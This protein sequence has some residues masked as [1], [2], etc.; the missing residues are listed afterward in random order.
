MDTLERLSL[1]K[2]EGK[3]LLSINE[4]TRKQILLQ[5][6]DTLLANVNF[7]L[8]ENKKDID[9][10]KSFLDS[11]KLDRLT[12]NPS[13]IES[14]AAG[15]KQISELETPT[16]KLLDAFI[17]ENGILI[18]KVS[19][20]IGLI[21]IIYESRPNVT[22]DC[23][24]LC[25]KSSN[26]L[27]LKGGKEANFSNLAIFNLIKEVLR[28]YDL[29][30]CIGFFE[31]KHMQD[32][33]ARDDL[34]DLIIPRGSN[35][36][37]NF[38]KQNTKIPILKHD[39]GVCHAYIHKS[40]NKDIA[41]SI[42]NNAKCSRPSVCNAL[43]CILVHKD[44]AK[45]FL[46]SLVKELKG[47]KFVLDSIS[48]EI[49]NKSLKDIDFRDLQEEDLYKEYGILEVNV[50]VVENTFEA[51]NHINKY[52]SNHSDCII[53]DDF[54]KIEQFLNEVDS[55]SVYANVSTRFSDG[56]EYGFGAEIGISTNKLHARGPVGLKELT[57]YKYKIRG[58][59]QIRI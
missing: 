48:K 59:G 9:L 18:E 45:S 29:Q 1:V 27:V 55:A 33:L 47:V 22:S 8:K 58:N 3:K 17:H 56:Y 38:I 46:P 41:L 15:V 42:C 16:N 36:L 52:S 5:I 23:I 11:S 12:L 51:I 37:I 50:K 10:A 53:S 24:A 6:H 43:E 28:K 13:R 44:I 39:A 57:T 40:A 34:I 35:N 21:C 4:A 54:D 30:E 7:I 32:L 19:V 25:L 2:K 14:M 31:S 26:A 49:L 20:P